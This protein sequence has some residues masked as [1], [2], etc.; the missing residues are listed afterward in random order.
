MDTTERIFALIEQNSVSA[1]Q[2]TREASLTSG[3]VSQ[4][5]HGKQKPGTDAIVKIAEYFGVTT[6]Y[7]LG[8]TDD[9]EPPVQLLDGL[10]FGLIKNFKKLGNEEKAELNRMAERMAELIELRKK[11]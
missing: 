3:V 6:D 8:K 11:K 4:W 1:A 2:L 9:P 10:E 7:L 5:R